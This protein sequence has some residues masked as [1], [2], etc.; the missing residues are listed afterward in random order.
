MIEYLYRYNDFDFRYNVDPTPKKY[1]VIKKTPQGVWIDLNYNWGPEEKKFVKL[2]AYK[3]FACETEEQAL[4][5]YIARKSRQ[6]KILKNQLA[7]AQEN[8]LAGI[9]FKN[10]KE[11]ETI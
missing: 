2:T 11:L 8:L 5:S 9:Q 7:R 6:I 4:E 3:K 1:K 10:K